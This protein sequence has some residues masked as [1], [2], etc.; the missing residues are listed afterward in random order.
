MGPGGLKRGSPRAAISRSKSPIILPPQ[1]PALAAERATDLLVNGQ[2]GDPRQDP[3]QR[4]LAPGR[5]RR[6]RG[7]DPYASR[8]REAYTRKTSTRDVEPARQRF[9]ASV[10][11]SRTGTR[12][13][14]R[15]PDRSTA[16][17]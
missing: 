10:G 16:A 12:Q 15:R 8:V 11:R 9:R 4:G 17:R 2:D 1:P 5:V 3:L 13:P 14:A 7:G 6:V